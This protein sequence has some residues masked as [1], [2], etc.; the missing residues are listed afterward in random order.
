MEKFISKMNK[1]NELHLAVAISSFFLRLEIP[2]LSRSSELARFTRLLGNPPFI[3]F[4]IIAANT[5]I[6]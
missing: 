6:N 5:P 4:A 2:T 3:S 1:F